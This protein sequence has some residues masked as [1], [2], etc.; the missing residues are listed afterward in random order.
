MTNRRRLYPDLLLSVT[1]FA[2]VALA[3][4]RVYRF[5]FDDEITTL[6]SMKAMAQSTGPGLLWA[7]LS[8]MNPPL[9][10]LIFYAGSAAG[11]NTDSLRWIS[12]FCTAGALASWHW[13]T[14]DAL[15]ESNPLAANRILIAILFGLTPLAI[16]QGDALRWYPPL[17]LA[18]AIAFVIYFTS[19]RWWLSGIAFGIAADLGF[20]ALLPFLAVMVCRLFGERQ[21]GERRLGW[22][23][24]GGFLL[25]T[26]L[27]A[28]PGFI[29]FIDL[30]RNR[31]FAGIEAIHYTPNLV[32]RALE[33]P[34]GFFGGVTLGL[35][36]AWLVA[37][38]IGATL[39]LAYRSLNSA[40]NRRATR[41]RNLIFI[42]AAFAAT[43]TLTGFSEPRAYLFLSPMI[44][45]L[46]AIGFAYA[47]TSSSGLAAASYAALIVVSIAVVAN[48]R[49]SDTPFKR[50][51]AIPY[52]EVMEFARANQGH[53]TV[54][55][56]TDPVVAYTLS[57]SPDVCTERFISWAKV[58]AFARCR[59]LRS[60]TVI[61]VTDMPLDDN[62]PT[63]RARLAAIIAGK[64]ALA[65]AHFGRD[66]DALLKNRLTGSRLPVTLVD[67]V[68]YR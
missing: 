48:L 25:L 3:A 62:D 50:N 17:A 18:I 7:N 47:I 22:R 43:F 4:G 42:T 64:S 40:S 32:R 57:D 20:I 12:M 44:S 45:A 23:E 49:A 9:F 30:I 58:W 68:V 27:F 55:V 10:R 39:W 54:V 24:E 5:P 51:A 63:W 11:L 56:T 46:A 60:D 52:A 33:T 38:A 2:L 31:R 15:A 14:L 34:L 61:V 6:W 16:S 67:A 1:T 59:N 29:S 13:L 28:T 8:E 53:K 26:G 65:E 37:L 19:A 41:L 66:K 36:Q 21:L 35:S